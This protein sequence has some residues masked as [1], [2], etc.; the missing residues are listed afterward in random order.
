MFLSFILFLVCYEDGMKIIPNNF[1]SIYRIS[2]IYVYSSW[3][4]TLFPADN[5]HNFTN[6][7][8]VDETADNEQSHQDIHS[9]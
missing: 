5:T 2:I 7:A 3:E 6:S 9:L 8:N 4:L 1:S